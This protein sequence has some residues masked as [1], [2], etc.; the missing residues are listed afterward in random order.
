MLWSFFLVMLSIVALLI[1]AGSLSLAS[2]GLMAAFYSPL[3]S[4]ADAWSRAASVDAP[5]VG[6]GRWTSV[7]LLQA[8][9]RDVS[10]RLYRS[11]AWLVLS[12]SGTGL[13][14]AP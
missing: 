8:S 6:G 9:D 3:S 7:V 2:K 13:I 5:I 4:S 14:C 1:V 10:E 12:V 11:G